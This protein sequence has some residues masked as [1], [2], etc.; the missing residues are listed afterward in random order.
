VRDSRVDEVLDERDAARAS[1][2]LFA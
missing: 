2:D 1:I